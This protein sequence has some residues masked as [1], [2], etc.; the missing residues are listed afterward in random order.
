MKQFIL[1]SGIFLTIN[2]ISACSGKESLTLEY[3]TKIEKKDDEIRKLKE[4]VKRINDQLEQ[5]RKNQEK[6]QVFDHKARNIMGHIA[7]H[8]F[9]KLKNEFDVNLE[10]IDGKIYFSELS[11]SSIGSYFP[12]EIAKFPMYFNF[13]NPQPDSTEVGYFL[14]GYD[15]HN[16]E[17]KYDIHF[18]FGKDDEF[19]YVGTD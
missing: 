1:L 6:L 14:Y 17:R 10:V 8:D 18:R 11:K 5:E 4:E 2:F 3:E 16:T 15:Q 13:Y 7:N 12:T 9:D 19:M